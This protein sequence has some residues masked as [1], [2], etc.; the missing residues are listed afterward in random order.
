ML[1]EINI[2]LICKLIVIKLSS[3]IINPQSDSMNKKT[4]NVLLI[5]PN[6]LLIQSLPSVPSHL[7]PSL[8]VRS[9]SARKSPQYKKR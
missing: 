3:L 8:R 5:R 9:S 6:A 2:I 4:A 7:K 1:N